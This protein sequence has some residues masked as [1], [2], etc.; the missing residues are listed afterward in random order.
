MFHLVRRERKDVDDRLVEGHVPGRYAY[1]SQQA[2]PSVQGGV[3]QII[4]LQHRYI[5]WIVQQQ[6][7]LLG[8]HRQAERQVERLRTRAFLDVTSRFG[9][10]LR[11][12]Q[13]K[14][15]LPQTQ[16]PTYCVDQLLRKIRGQHLESEDQRIG[17]QLVQ[18]SLVL[19]Q[20]LKSCQMTWPGQK[21][22][23]ASK[24]NR[25]PRRSKKIAQ[26][27]QIHAL[28]HGL[29]KSQHPESTTSFEAYLANQ[30]EPRFFKTPIGYC[31]SIVSPDMQPPPD[32]PNCRILD[33]PSPCP[34]PSMLTGLQKSRATCGSF[35]QDLM[36][37]V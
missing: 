21:E 33:R 14:T 20:R 34:P 7:Q 19:D 25:P 5:K 29:N 13:S 18:R 36:I 2:L 4:E 6:N 16:S 31:G 15:F 10:Q 9:F 11:Q 22:T 1:G 12:A 8:N 30:N 3:I 27:K 35:R 37:H 24:G 26:S 32:S 28:S 17:V 23:C